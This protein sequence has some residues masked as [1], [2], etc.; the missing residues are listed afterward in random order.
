MFLG[1]F[2]LNLKRLCHLNLAFVYVLLEYPVAFPT[3]PQPHTPVL[4]K[5]KFKVAQC[6]LVR[7]FLT[8]FFMPKQ[9]QSANINQTNK[10]TSIIF[11]TELS[12]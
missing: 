12:E 1:V 5:K 10:L 9:T 3:K 7:Y 8:Y 2:S 4:E 6:N 11:M